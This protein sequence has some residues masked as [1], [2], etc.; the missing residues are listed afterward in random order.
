MNFAG[1]TLILIRVSFLA[2]LGLD[3][4]GLDDTDFYF[5]LLLLILDSFFSF[6]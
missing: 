6:N 5:Y 3:M 2:E 1:K 4:I